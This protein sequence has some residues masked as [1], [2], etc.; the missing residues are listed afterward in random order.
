MARTTEHG[1]P[2]DAGVALGWARTTRGK[3]WLGCLLALV[4]ATAAVAVAVLSDPRP[5]GRGTAS[6]VAAGGAATD[7]THRCLNQIPAPADSGAP[8]RSTRG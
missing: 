8:Q 7:T 2:D 6:D 5:G 4:L 3:V 1:T